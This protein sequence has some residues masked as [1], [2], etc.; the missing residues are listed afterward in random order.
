MKLIIEARFEDSDGGSGPPIVVCEIE[1]RD[2][3]LDDLGLTLAQGR[4]LL[5][6]VQS[7]LV[8]QQAQRWLE[9][10][11]RCRRCGQALA[12]KDTRSIV[13]RT[14]FGKIAVPS[15]R[16]WSCQCGSDGRRQTFSPMSKGITHRT[17]L[18]L[19]CLQTRWAAHLP[20]RQ[21]NSLLKEVLPLSQAIS[22]STT[23]AVSS[24]WANASIYRFNTTSLNNRITLPP[25]LSRA[26]RR[27]SPAL[28]SIPPG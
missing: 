8:S 22:F 25:A 6:Q 12:H 20:Y 21:A 9:Q 15:P 27:T 2:G 14:A 28:P 10:H 16:W 17:T 7:R 18:E 26:S 13:V 11:S 19:E 24:Q 5:G 23:D 3:N 4:D 1:R